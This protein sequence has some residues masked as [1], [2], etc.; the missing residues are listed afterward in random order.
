M[1]PLNAAP[2]V[3]N[4]LN[5]NHDLFARHEHAFSSNQPKPRCDRTDRNRI[6]K[7]TTLAISLITYFEIERGL[8]LPRYQVKNARSKKWL[9]QLEVFPIDQNTMD[10]AAR[11]WQ[12]LRPKGL[13]LED[14]DTVIAATALCEDAVLVTDNTKHFARI[15]HLQLEN[16]IER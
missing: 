3:P 15:P 1:N 6:R 2:C 10:V 4:L 13:I 12:Q 8:E 5:L 7:R 14:A 16:W 11:I 9:T